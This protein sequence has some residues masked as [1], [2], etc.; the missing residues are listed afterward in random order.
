[1]CN[2]RSTAKT[3]AQHAV[4]PYYCTFTVGQNIKVFYYGRIHQWTA[5][6]KRDSHWVPLCD[7]KSWNE[8]MSAITQGV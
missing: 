8:L 1:M 7:T 4:F 3:F 6:M 5:L 2:V